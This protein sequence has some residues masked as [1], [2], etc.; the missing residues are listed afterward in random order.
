VVVHHACIYLFLRSSWWIPSKVW[1]SNSCTIRWYCRGTA[2]HLQ[3]G[4]FSGSQ[5]SLV[6]NL[7]YTPFLLVLCLWASIVYHI[8]LW[9]ES[10][11]IFLF[12]TMCP[13]EDCGA[14]FNS[15][16]P[17]VIRDCHVERVPG[18]LQASCSHNGWS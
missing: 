2:G 14:K 3:W 6:R 5:V 12:F 7:K 15:V 9:K 8:D 1:K 11:S 10:Q 4:L 16:L 13:Q 17:E 18:E